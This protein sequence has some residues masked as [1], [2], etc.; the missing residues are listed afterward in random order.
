MHPNWEFGQLEQ[1]QL[2]YK[3]TI[4]LQIQ[5]SLR[6][7]SNTHTASAWLELV[8]K[9]PFHH[10]KPLKVFYTFLLPLR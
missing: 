3:L 8:L 6:V 5:Q 7:E 4:Y 1:Q 2:E 9:H 10:E